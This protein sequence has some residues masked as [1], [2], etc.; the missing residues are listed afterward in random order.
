[1]MTPVTGQSI[2]IIGASSG[3]GAALARQLHSR[4][5]TLILSGR[6][7]DALEDLKNS[8]GGSHHV[9]AFDVTNSDEIQKAVSAVRQI[10]PRLDRVIYMAG[11]YEPLA[12]KDVSPD[13]IHQIT[14][15]NLVG[16]MMVVQSILPALLQQGQGQIA[17]CGSVAGYVGLPNAQPY[18]A[19]KAALINFAESLRTELS[20]SGI[21]IRVI[22]PGFVRTPMTAKNNFDMPFMISSEEAAS[23]IADGLESSHFEIHFPR[24]LTLL[25]KFLKLLPYGLFFRITEK[26]NRT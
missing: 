3:I 14:Q 21:D 25:M 12:F 9:V 23:C 18:S 11:H 5:A 10:V 2:W 17:L 24:R 26:L 4:G 8:L 7:A 19:T 13:L 1:M 6:R 16:A 22:N 15:T 20:S